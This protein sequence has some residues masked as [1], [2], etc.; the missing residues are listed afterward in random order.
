MIVSACGGDEEPGEI[1][2]SGRAIRTNPYQAKTR[3]IGLF[4]G[5]TL[6]ASAD[7]RAD[8]SFL[9]RAK[10]TDDMEQA[11][12]ARGFVAFT[13]RGSSLPPEEAGY[14]EG[15]RD[16]RV[17]FENGR[18][19]SADTKAPVSLVFNGKPFTCPDLVLP[20]GLPDD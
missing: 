10:R 14:C 9:I 12:S 7:V 16:L 13:L 15:H 20:F 2:A 4:L 6:V 5:D 18:W 8:G 11:Q 3:T 17:R 1:V 19:V